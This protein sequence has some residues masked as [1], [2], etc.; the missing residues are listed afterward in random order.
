M[1]VSGIS[2]RLCFQFRGVWI[3]CPMVTRIGH[4]YCFLRGRLHFLITLANTGSQGVLWTLKCQRGERTNHLPSNC[5]NTISWTIKYISQHNI[6]STGDYDYI[7]VTS[8]SFTRGKGRHSH[9][10]LG[11]LSSI[12]SSPL[13]PSSTL[14]PFPPSNPHHHSHSLLHPTPTTLP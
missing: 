9:L 7:M 2:R 5:R 3:Y 12:L 14:P 1:R 8:N 13:Y 6:L 11:G 4:V 10:P